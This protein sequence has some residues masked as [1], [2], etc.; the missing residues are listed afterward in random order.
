MMMMIMILSFCA[1]PYSWNSLDCVTGANA[2]QFWTE[3]IN[4]IHEYSGW[5]AF[6][7]PWGFFSLYFIVLMVGTLFDVR[8]L[9]YC[10]DHGHNH[11]VDHDHHHHY[12]HGLRHLY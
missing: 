1:L 5:L 11:D 3:R 8:V 4:Q 9:E 10:E 2:T 7:L 12:V 6:G